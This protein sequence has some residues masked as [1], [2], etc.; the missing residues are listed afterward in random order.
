VVR[1]R[2]A[3]KC[4][5]VLMTTDSEWPVDSQGHLNIILKDKT[6]VFFNVRDGPYFPTLRMLHMCACAIR[7]HSTA[8]FD[9]AEYHLVTGV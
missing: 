8:M 7:M 4:V 9:D 2:A 1:A 3:R 6:P 5:V